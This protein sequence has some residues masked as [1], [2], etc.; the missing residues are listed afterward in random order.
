MKSPLHSIR[1]SARPISESGTV[2]PSAGGLNVDDQ[3]EFRPAGFSPFENSA[4]RNAER[5]RVHNGGSV[6]YQAVSRYK[7]AK[8][9]DRGHRV[10]GSA[11]V[12]A[13]LPC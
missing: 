3:L 6:T 5:V 7:L 10:A 4:S 12:V 8:L 2:V 9:V 1:S 11:N 13:T